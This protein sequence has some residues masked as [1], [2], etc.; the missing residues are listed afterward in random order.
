MKTK[1]LLTKGFTLIELLVVIAII[2]ILASLL[3]P[4]L[5]KAK[6][7]AQRAKCVSNLK[8][9]GLSFRM[10]SNDHGDKFPFKIAPPEGSMDSANQQAYRHFLVMSNEL[11]TPKILF[12]PSDANK[13]QVTDWNA[14]NDSHVSYLVGYDAEE[15]KPQSIL[16][17]DRNLTDN[18]GG[19]LTEG[20]CS[21]FGS[22]K[23]WSLTSN[24]VW[25]A[26]IHNNG[27]DLALADGS[28]QQTTSGTLKSQAMASDTD[29][30]NNHVKAP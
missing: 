15:T 14:L 8:Q 9:V 17:G 5:A 25:S 30:Y 19:A 10:Y 7:R 20:D 11:N 3:L 29:N 24:C 18:S 12:C 21:A 1:T 2:A 16:S 23:A 22:A 28:V 6:A 13:S 4:A 26:S 27:G